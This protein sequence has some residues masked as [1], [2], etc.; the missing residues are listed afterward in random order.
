MS[1]FNIV[2][3]ITGAQQ[4]QRDRDTSILEFNERVLSLSKFDSTPLLEKMRFINI[5][6]NNLIEFLS[7]RIPDMKSEDYNFYKSK[8]ESMHESMNDST[9]SCLEEFKSKYG[10]RQWL[11]KITPMYTDTKFTDSN[12]YIMY[13]LDMKHWEFDLINDT[14]SFDED[15]RSGL[16]KVKFY[17]MF[18]LISNRRID[19]SNLGNSKTKSKKEISEMV[20]TE[21]TKNF[22]YALT[23]T[24]SFNI[25]QT[26]LN[27][28]G[29]IVQDII[30]VPENVLCIGFDIKYF[31]NRYSDEDIQKEINYSK[32]NRDYNE[33][34]EIDL[35]KSNGSICYRV[36]YDSYNHILHYIDQLC[37]SEKTEV[38]YISLYRVAGENSILVN[39]LCKAA[40]NG[41]LV[42][43]YIEKM[44]RGD[45]D[46]NIVIA[47]KLEKSGCHVIL[48][49]RDYKVHAKIFTAITSDGSYSHIGTGNYNEKTAK[50]YTDT[51]I[52]TNDIEV[53]KSISNIF[54]FILSQS[55]CLRKSDEL[56]FSP[57]NSREEI[58]KAIDKEIEKGKDG[59]IFIKCNSL[60]DNQI[61]NKLT[62]AGRFNVQV[63]IIVRGANALIPTNNIEIRSKVGRYL[64]HDR[65]YIIGDSVYIS[66]ADLLFRNMDKR[67]EALYK[68]NN[69]S[70]KDQIVDIFM[71]I[72]ESNIH[73]LDTSDM[74]WKYL[75]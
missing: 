69:K 5:V 36:P 18:R 35:V 2:R 3:N 31:E 60:C 8:I 61:V 27:S 41:I 14:N 49:C 54:E 20:N 66:S 25:V 30:R 22:A 68:I 57:F 75:E 39:S 16:D 52:L 64:E 59:R 44:A 17:F 9:I 47:N 37:S 48:G 63:R 56:F 23:S 34:D 51:H 7:I 55:F 26:A 19:Y 38:I 67:I 40:A 4:S 43:A 10:V 71:N 33:C 15:F 12:L 62:I 13:T 53:S 1:N 21:G 28:V 32:D 11:S 42:Y 72:W 74:T 50:I 58:L 45:E 70:I 73:Y 65:I 29:I 24:D 46:D 6:E